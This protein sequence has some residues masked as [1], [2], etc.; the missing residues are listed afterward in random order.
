MIFE[1]YKNLRSKLISIFYETKKKKTKAM[2][3]LL[4][5]LLIGLLNYAIGTVLPLTAIQ[6]SRGNIGW[7]GE[8]SSL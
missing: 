8:N 6:I 1:I 5:V 7:Q 3:F 2:F 4:I